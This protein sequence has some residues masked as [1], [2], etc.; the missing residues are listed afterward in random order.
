[1]SAAPQSLWRCAALLLVVSVL[2][3]LTPQQADAQYS[4]V[5]YG[6]IANDSSNTAA[7]AN[8]NAFV[9]AALAA[10]A[11]A[12]GSSMQR[13][14]SVPA[15]MTFTVLNIQLS[16]LVNVTLQIDGTLSMAN[17]ISWWPTANGGGG[18]LAA[19]YI[20]IPIATTPIKRSNS[21]QCL[22]SILI[23]LIDRLIDW[24]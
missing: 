18:S 23:R 2:V 6:A 24:F 8:T 21:P 5:N 7:T 12:P 10:N 17:N 15:N 9:R 22:V 4:I 16:N 20:G 14:V 1:M 3:L 19:L 13:V 11:T